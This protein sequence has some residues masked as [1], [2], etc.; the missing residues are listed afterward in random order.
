MRRGLGMMTDMGMGM[1]MVRGE[2]R[3]RGW[4]KCV[5][6]TFFFEEGEMAY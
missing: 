3:G 2:R 4:V 5:V 1:E 6:D